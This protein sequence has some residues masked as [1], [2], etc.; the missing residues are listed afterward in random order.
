MNRFTVVSHRSRV[1]VGVRATLQYHE[2]ETSGLNGEFEADLDP[3]A[4]V[5][6]KVTGGLDLPGDSLRSGNRLFDR[7]LR[8]LLEVKKYRQISG[9]I[10]EVAADPSSGE[11]AVRGALSLHGVTHEVNGTARIVD[12]GPSHVIIE[13]AMPLDFTEYNMEQPTLLMLKVAPEVEI[14]GTLYAER[15]S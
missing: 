10:L 8:K 6:S 9:K 7:E 5:R 1:V 4:G 3:E 14:K 11:Y 12:I 13:G 2:I 15:Q